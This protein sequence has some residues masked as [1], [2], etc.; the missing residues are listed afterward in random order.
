MDT[1]HD[2]RRE[3]QWLTK[4]A[5]FSLNSSHTPTQNAQPVDHGRVGIGTNQRIGDCERAPLSR[6]N[7]NAAAQIFKVNL[8]ANPPARRNQRKVIKALLGP[9]QEGEA[10]SIALGSAN[11]YTLFISTPSAFMGC[12]RFLNYTFSTD[13]EG[14]SP[15]TA[16]DRS[17]GSAWASSSHAIA[18]TGA[19]RKSAR[20]ST[21]KGVR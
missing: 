12:L 11:V 7:L 21:E 5:R 3:K 13:T 15:L 20:R 1:Y 8:M 17:G 2:W 9:A 4:Q 18:Q 10:L 14:A 19:Q 6:L 16:C